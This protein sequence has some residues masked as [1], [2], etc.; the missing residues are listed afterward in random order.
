MH[1]VSEY[2]VCLVT[3]GSQSEGE[4]IADALVSE[5][6]A[7]CVN[8]LGP[9]RSVY[10]WEGTVHRDEEL[11]LIIKTRGELFGRVSARVRALHSYRTPEVIALPV[12][13]GSEDYLAWLRAATGGAGK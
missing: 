13:A 10:R 8:L 7:A 3:V 6:L 5:E 12:T 1:A 9:I 4:R 11:L 2:V